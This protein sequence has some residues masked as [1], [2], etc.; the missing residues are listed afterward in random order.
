[1]DME[2]MEALG[3]LI[4]VGFL[5]VVAVSLMFA[6]RLLFHNASYDREMK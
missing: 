6:A 5:I 3:P 1:M 4:E 2:T